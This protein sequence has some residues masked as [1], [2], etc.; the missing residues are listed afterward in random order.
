MNLGGL[1][2]GLGTT[3]SR[4]DLFGRNRNILVILI[5]IIVIFGFG[6]GR[7]LFGGAGGFGGYGGAGGG[8]GFGGYTEFRYIDP[9]DRRRSTKHRH[10]NKRYDDD[11]I[12]AY[13]ARYGYANPGF[14]YGGYGINP[15]YGG[16][17]Y[18]GYASPYGGFFG[19]DWWFIIA[20]IALLFLLGGDNDSA[21]DNVAGANIG[22]ICC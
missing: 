6:Y 13:R 11:E 17:G 8:G 15:G 14:E 3:G 4:N 21:D 2:T 22:N 18:A 16:P 9:P 7:G 5:I 10:K 1:F 20:V 12:I 19:N